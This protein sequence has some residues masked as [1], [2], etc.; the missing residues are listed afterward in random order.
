MAKSYFARCQAC[1]QRFEIKPGTKEIKCP[2]CGK[3]WAVTWEAPDMARIW[4]KQ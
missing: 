1:A 2:H 4:P 3:E